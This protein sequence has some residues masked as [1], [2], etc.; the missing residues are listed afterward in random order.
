MTGSLPEGKS[1]RLVYS[2]CSLNP[3][4][5]EA[6]VAALLME[7]WREGI[8]L[9]LADPTS[10]TSGDGSSPLLARHLPGIR[11]RPGLSS[12]ASDADI[13]LAG[14]TD[15]KEREESRQR[16]PP[17]SRSMSCPQSEEMKRELCLERCMRILPQDMDTG[18]F[19]IAVLEMSSDPLP[20]RFT[21]ALRA[22]D[23]RYIVPQTSDTP[24]QAAA[25]KQKKKRS[26][27][28]L[29]LTQLTGE[30]KLRSMQTFQ[31]LGYNP[32]TASQERQAQQ[33][34]E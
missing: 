29:E 19:F 4:E 14:E 16:L 34:S 12:W 20:V 13:M 3:I 8:H 23:N 2:T 7:F 9:R 24:D 15:P 10:L 1:C 17:L 25:A 31:A 11:W 22:E 26:A 33:A 28:S 27:E 6:V 5:D 18:G 32:H 30:K 21:E